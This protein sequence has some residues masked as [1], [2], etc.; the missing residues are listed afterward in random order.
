MGE[1]EL[2]GEDALQ[3]RIDACIYVCVHVCM[4]APLGVYK[5]T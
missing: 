3:S 5:S 4:Y 2:G 1:A